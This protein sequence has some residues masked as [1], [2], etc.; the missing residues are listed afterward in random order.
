[1]RLAAD[2]LI[3]IV[4]IGVAL[5][6]ALIYQ[7]NTVARLQVTVENMDARIAYVERQVEKLGDR[8]GIE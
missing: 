5:V 7:T 6:G 2:N 1:M 8:R 4:S 3:A